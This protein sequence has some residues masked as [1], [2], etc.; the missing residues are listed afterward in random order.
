MV[1]PSAFAVLRLMTSSNFVGCATGR[2]DVGRGVPSQLSDTD[3]VGHE[4]SVLDILPGPVDTGQSMLLGQLHERAPVEKGDGIGRDD[5]PR[6]PFFLGPDQGGLEILRS[7]D[8]HER[9]AH[10]EHLHGALQLA[11]I[12]GHWIRRSRDDGESRCRWQRLS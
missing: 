8:G 5:D 11:A 9:H 3:T 6:C 2:S 1:R 10:S 4:A 7:A 12:F